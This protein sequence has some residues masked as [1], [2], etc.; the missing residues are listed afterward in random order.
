MR[1]STRHDTP[2]TTGRARALRAAAA[3]AATGAALAVLPAGTA[4]AAG[5]KPV[6]VGPLL[7]IFTFGA[8]VGVPTGCQA[9]SASLG[10][11]S[12]ELGLAQQAAPVV[13]AVNTGCDTFQQQADA[14]IA[15]GQQQSAPLSVLNPTVNPMIGQAAASSDQFAAEYGPALAPF[16]GTLA[17][18][19]ATLNFFQGS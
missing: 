8:D 17:G 15:M 10:S 4:S 2:R 9:G 12:A 7:Q 3:L 19:G 18:V 6:V 14:G 16:G 1:Q 5:S 11:G 13:S